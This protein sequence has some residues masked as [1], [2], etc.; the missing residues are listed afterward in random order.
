MSKSELK[1]YQEYEK[2]YTMAKSSKAFS[3]FCNETFGSDF[4][5]DGFSDLNQVKLIL[6]SIPHKPNLKILDIGCGNGKLLAYLQ[7]QSNC[8]IYG[9]DYSETAIK[10]AQELHPINSSF[11][12]GVIGETT[13]SENYFDVIISMDTIYFADDMN[14][15]IGQVKRWLKPDGMFIVG[16]QEGDVIPKTNTLDCSQI[17]KCFDDNN[18]IYECKDLTYET[19][20]LLNKKRKVAMKYKNEFEKENNSEW[21]D[22]LIW[23]TEYANTTFEVYQTK[24]SRYFFIARN[25]E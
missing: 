15:F 19:Y 8:H 4:S 23:Q 17:V 5:Q 13:Y 3:S 25:P 1:F 12:V 20:K 14:K 24:M 6:S 18:M 7:K 10:T 2:F 21:Y 11:K 16:Y 9:F 22:M